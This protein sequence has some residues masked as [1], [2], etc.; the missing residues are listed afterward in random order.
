MTALASGRDE[1]GT[2]PSPSGSDEAAGDE[3]RVVAS[4]AVRSRRRGGVPFTADQRAAVADRGGSALLAANAGSGK[5]AVMV[6]RFVEAVLDDGV[7]VGAILALTFTEKAAGELRERVRRRFTAL[8]ELDAAREAEAAWIGTIHGFCARVL[9]ARPL[10]AGL[11]PR[12]TVLDE[13]A[14]RRL[15]DQAYDAALDAW[16]AAHGGPAVD[17]A[18]AYGPGLR[19]MMTGVHEALRSRGHSR[20]RLP[21]PSAAGA[22]DPAALVAARDAAAAALRTAGDGK[23]V[24]AAREAL[25]ALVPPGDGSTP[26]PGDLD[27]AKLGSGAKALD[28]RACA[29]YRAAWEAYR[30]ACADHH[31]GAALVL[32]DDLLD[33]F[34]AAY[35]TAK[36]ARAAVD[37]S[38]LELR[39]RDLLEGEQTRRSWAERFALIMVDEFQ[40]T[41]RLQLDVL[42]ALER[43]NLF[44]V[45][46]ELQSIYGFRHADVTIF[47][48][49]RARL[50]ADRVRSLVHNFRSAAPLLDVLNGAFEHELGA[51][52]TPLV[53]GARREPAPAPAAG[54]P[55]R[56]FD[57]DGA[58]AAGDPLVEL[59]VTDTR[60]WDQPELERAV[61]LAG[62][63]SQPWRRAEAR[64]VAHRLRAEVD[65]GRRPGDI[66]VLVRATGSLRLL[67]QA[68]EEQGL[69]TYVVGGRGYW[70][71]EQVRDGIAYLSA[72]ANPQDEEALLAVLASP[73]CG[74]GTDALVLLTQ[75]GRESGRG[76]W[77][78]LRDE[79]QRPGHA[80]GWLRHLPDAERARLEAFVRF[81]ARERPRAER[82]PAETLLER[83]V[84][85]TGY[86]LAVLA[87]SGGDRRLANLRKLMRLA[88]DYE[89]AEGSNLRGFLAYAVTQDLAE[90]REGEAALESDGLDAVRLMTIHRAKGLEFPVV[91]VADLGRAAATVRDRLLVGAGGEVGLRLAPIGGGDAIPALAWERLA[92]AGKQAEDEEERRL[93]YVAMTRARERL[94]LSGGVDCERLPA[95]RPGGPPIDWILRALGGE[96]DGVGGPEILVERDGARLLCRVNAPA[97]LGTV[98]PHAALSPAG[99]PRAGAPGTALPDA[100]AV[101]PAP[102]ARPRPAPQRLSYSA[103]GAYARCGY[104]FYLERVLGLP[105]AA[106]PAPAEVVP[107]GGDE[108]E[109]VVGG[110][111]PL[112]RGSLVHRLLEGH[113]FARPAAP[114]IEAVAELAGEWG[115]E[116]T[117]AELEDVRDLVAAFAS[118][119]LCARLAQARR[120]RSEAP[121]SFTLD[122]AGGGPLVTGFLDV[123][124]TE[125]D[126][127]VLIVDY[128]SDRLE[129]A[130]PA[131]VVERDYATQRI[132][133][134]LAAL[135]DGAPRVEVAYCFLERPAE[136][137]TASF[138]DQPALAERLAGLAADLLAGRYPVTATPHRELCGDCPGRAAMCSWPESATLG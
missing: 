124:A 95:P 44:A 34:G 77:A 17:L 97:T 132:V 130:A 101:L 45:G 50:T 28:D 57:P 52:F 96:V 79:V 83:A 2:V 60:G 68:L 80:Q 15:A 58:P 6:E 107:P 118:S 138:T 11:D 18:A 12:F 71:Q 54:E 41:N 110:L 105:R 74:V 85:A 116:P 66:V 70:S 131:D 121:F 114:A 26:W 65:A 111:D 53:A 32:L 27:A 137:V 5:T 108:V 61:G 88:R 99:R 10:A 16:A 7:A 86:D 119:P 134:A 136:P 113:D 39:V 43:D 92:Q 48:E 46:D 35:E 104:R 37:F 76:A 93:F 1:A 128:K 135:R 129:G 30:S 49:R 55:L 22:P 112:V 133:Y 29:D 115:L 8:G 69:P 75:A 126:G 51:A 56:L 67:E 73:F 102:P 123:V 117:M 62:G 63:G 94:I 23:K 81:F 19:E 72:L 84:V 42:E 64:L 24:G 122:P 87:R 59:L 14:A 127:G 40:D 109:G 13:A 47:R 100:P 125:S 103:L 25:D 78:A 21:L 36:T 3:A 89:R 120:T 31:A 38:D 82:A 4:P 20:P 90:A 91:C 9:R 98:L 106:P 33:R